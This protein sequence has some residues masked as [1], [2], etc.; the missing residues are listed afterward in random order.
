MDIQRV[1]VSGSTGLIGSALCER[2]ITAGHRLLP[3]VR[4]KQSEEETGP[5]KSILWDPAH[6]LLAPQQLNHIDCLIHLAGRSIASARWTAKEKQRI[7]DSRVRATRLLVEQICQLDTP[8]KTFIS[9]S[10][11][12]I[13][14]DHAAEEVDE[15]TPRGDDFLADVASDWEDAC[16]PLVQFGVRV[17]HPRLGI[18]LSREGGALA[19]LLPLFRW[20]LGGPVGSGKQYW[21]WV[22]LLDVVS[23]IEWMMRET[24]ASGAYNVVAPQR[25]SNA[26]FTK[27]LAR[28]L[29]V[30]AILPAPAWGMR[31][32]LGEMADALLLSSCRVVPRRLLDAGFQF[33]YPQ[34]GPFLAA[35][36]EHRLI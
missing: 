3:V 21:S 28:Q 22:A 16:Q 29:G 15:T 1:A 6:G 2:L 4:V 34:L 33:Q 20:M 35:E 23:A 31:L 12:G 19:K 9:A 13:Y 17:V 14:G 11:I 8:P 32:A 18:V 30:P 25:T 27:T 5:E 24:S 7:R 36:L 10:A 26:E